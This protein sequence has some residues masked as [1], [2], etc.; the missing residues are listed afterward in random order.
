MRYLTF[1]CAAWLAAFVTEGHEGCASQAGHAHA[2]EEKRLGVGEFGCL[3]VAGH[4]HEEHAAHDHGHDDHAHAAKEKMVGDHAHAHAA[5]GRG[6]EVSGAAAEAIGLTVTRP[7]LRRLA[8]THGF[9]GRVVADPLAAREIA[10]P[11]AGFVQC[12]VRP[13]DDVAAGAPLLRLVSP[14]AAAQTAEIRTLAARLDAVTRAGAKNAALAAEL[15]ARR[16]AYAAATQGLTAIDAATGTFELAAPEAGRVT[17]L[18]CATGG[19]AERGAAVLRLTARRPPVVLALV[20]V[21]DA[22]TWADGLAAEVG[23][24]RGTVRLDRTRTDGLVGVWVAGLADAPLALGET[25]RVTL[26]ASADAAAVPCVP[27]AAVFRD[28]LEPAVFVRDA[29]D[30]DRFVVKPVGLGA[31][32]GGWTAVTGLSDADEVVVQGVYEL[33]QALPA[34][35]GEKKVAGHFH[36]DGAF[37]AGDDEEGHE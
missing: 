2:H 25:V 6:V 10:L 17:E 9:Y 20:P 31:S 15:A 18:L 26:E 30:A 23:A 21:A 16:A 37:H 1:V 35:G 5:E 33:K 13:H 27:S 36:A 12:V 24:A 3:D 19:F 7:T 29:H 22:R 4:A 14:D 8:A 34:L 28:G 11:L 32:V